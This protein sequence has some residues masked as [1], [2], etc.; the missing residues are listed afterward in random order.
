MDPAGRLIPERW[1]WHDPASRLSEVL[2][3]GGVLAVPSESSYG[4]AVDPRD[5][6][7]VAAIYR[8]K[9]REAG[10]PLPVVVADA[11]Q[12]AVLGVA[13]D[14]PE[15]RAVR[16]LWPAPLTVLVP[17]AADL[18]AAAGEPRLAVR[19][20]GHAGLRRL[21]QELG[22]LTATSANLAGEPPILNP[23]DLAPLLAGAAAVVV[24]DGVLPGGAPSTLVAW[25]GG[26]LQVLRPGAFD[27]SVLPRR[28]DVG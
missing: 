25:P 12:L 5:A 3:G 7:G 26:E 22:P 23:D 11:A 15:I 14:A 20:P 18:P 6:R 19:V 9:R 17:L 21:C 24:D 28:L 8:L 10:K 4:L 2:A 27:P 16:D 13:E 1:H